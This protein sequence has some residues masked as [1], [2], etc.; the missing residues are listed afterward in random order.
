MPRKV[1][2]STLNGFAVLLYSVGA[3]SQLPEDKAKLLE[4]FS[5][6]SN[7]SDNTVAKLGHELLESD[8]QVNHEKYLDFL[9][10]ANREKFIKL[11]GK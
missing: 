10:P 11:C 4:D 1:N 5:N 3:W 6:D 8:F 9:I 2:L 7:N